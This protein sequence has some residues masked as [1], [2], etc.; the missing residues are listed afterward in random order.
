VRSEDE[1]RVLFGSEYIYFVLFDFEDLASAANINARIWRVDP[2]T[3]AFSY[4][5]IDY[6]YNIRSNSNSSAPFNMWPFK[7]KFHLLSPQ[8]IYHATISETDEINTVIFEGARGVSRVVPLPAL[9]SYARS[10]REALSVQALSKV[11]RNLSVACS[12]TTK[13]GILGELEIARKNGLPED[14]LISSLCDG[15]YAERIRGHEFMLPP[16]VPSPDFY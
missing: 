9:T 8:L 10:G 16:E 1:L 5:M 7:L 3:K 11:A 13:T 6:Y 2:K 12:Q 4:C 15:L 14:L